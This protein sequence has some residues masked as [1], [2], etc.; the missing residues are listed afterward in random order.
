MLLR[1]CGM[2][3]ERP[4]QGGGRTGERPRAAERRKEEEKMCWSG[5]V[6]ALSVEASAGRRGYL[7]SLYTDNQGPTIPPHSSSNHVSFELEAVS[8]IS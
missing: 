2:N 1:R 5:S 6:S 7:R 4:G 8:R 3:D